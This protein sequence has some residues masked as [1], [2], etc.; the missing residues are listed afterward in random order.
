MEEPVPTDRSTAASCWPAFRR[1]WPCSSRTRTRAGARI[2]SN[3]WGGG[4]PGAY[5]A[6]CEQLDRFVWQHKDMCVLVAAGNDGTD[7]DG[8]G[9]INPM[10]VTSPG[11][12]KNCITV[13]ASEN[14]RPEFDAETYGEWWPKRLSRWRRSRTARWRTTPVRLSRSAVEAPPPMGDS[15]L[16]CWR[17]GR[18]SSPRVR[19][20]S[21]RTTRRG[22][23]FRRAVCISTWAARAWPRR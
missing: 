2:H 16:T 3:S 13:G 6:Q 10:S 4:D 21:R 5:D 11:T 7:K 8:D 9:V 18:L 15:S 14:E 22:P 19:R 17:R 12:A 1:I 23:H 20:G